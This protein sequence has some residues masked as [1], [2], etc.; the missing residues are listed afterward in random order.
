MKTDGMYKKYVCILVA[1]LALAFFGCREK[2]SPAW[3]LEFESAVEGVW[4]VGKDSE[5]DFIYIID[6]DSTGSSG[7]LS[8]E[9]KGVEVVS[10]QFD[11]IDSTTINIINAT[12]YKMRSIKLTL[13]KKIMF[14]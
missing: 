14:N 11:I 8:V 6:V 2:N 10:H 9:S 1:L 4:E 3:V 13:W 12:S 7:T 5:L